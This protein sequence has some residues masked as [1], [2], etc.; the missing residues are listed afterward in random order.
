MQVDCVVIFE[1]SEDQQL[2]QPLTELQWGTIDSLFTTFHDRTIHSD[3]L[4]EVSIACQ[5]TSMSMF[6]L[7][8]ENF[9]RWPRYLG[10]TFA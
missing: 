3:S 10:S 4:L 6:L 9:K 2:S 7:L 5:A 1:V 8:S